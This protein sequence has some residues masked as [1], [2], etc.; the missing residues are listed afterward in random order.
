MRRCFSLLAVTLFLGT[1]AYALTA[2]DL[3]SKPEDWFKT[4]EATTQID[5]IISWQR[6]EGGW[7]KP[8]DASSPHDPAKPFFVHQGP[9]TVPYPA[10]EGEEWHGVGTIDNGITY[11]EMRVLAKAYKL[12]KRQNQLDSFNKALAFLLKS[13]YPNG[14]FPQRYPLADN[15]G[16]YITLNDTAMVNVMRLLREI[17]EN[18]DNQFPFVDE[19]IRAKCKQSFDRGVECLLKLQVVVNGTPTAWAQQYDP[20]TLQPAKARAYELPGLSGDESATAVLLLMELENPSPAV[21]R[22]IHAAVAW[23][24]RSKITGLKIERTADDVFTVPDPNGEPLWARYYEL[25]TNRPFFCGRD[26]IKKY[27]LMQIEKERRKGYAWIRPWG[28]P[29]LQKY[30]HWAAM[31]PQK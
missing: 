24:E 17:S 14:G 1:V 29:V 21:Q 23:F 16:R 8:Y 9:A 20:D 26:G 22:A 30:P 27:E 31:Y 10:K 3:K 4:D 15:Y 5:N 13:Q 11:T 7:E 18:R 12:T 28:K 19:A 2:N 6:P 25:D